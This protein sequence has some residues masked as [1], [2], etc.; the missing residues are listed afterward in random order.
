MRFSSADRHRPNLADTA[1]ITAVADPGL[2][3]VDRRHDEHETR[4]P[5]GRFSNGIISVPSPPL[6]S[7][8]WTRTWATRRIGPHRSITGS[9]LIVT[10]IGY[11]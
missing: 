6:T 8:T 3:R 7:A 5:S 4:M 10:V 2:K 9:H 1:L 11:G